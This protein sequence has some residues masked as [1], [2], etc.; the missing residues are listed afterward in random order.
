MHLAKALSRRT[1]AGRAWGVLSA[2]AVTVLE[3]LLFGFHGKGGLAYP[4]YESIAERAACARST[5]AEAIKTLESC[6][7]IT[8][9]NRLVRIREAGRTRLLR[10]SNGYSFIDPAPRASA[11]LDQK[12]R[13]C[14]E[15]CA[16]C[17]DRN[18]PL[19]EVE[20][21]QDGACVNEEGLSEEGRGPRER[22]VIEILERCKNP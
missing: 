9:V 15:F 6:G 13:C 18:R 3:A 8:W 7:I 16:G 11:S 19:L 21:P 22:D 10:M 20:V 1:V 4:S 12:S 17:A 14:E 2:K 5:V